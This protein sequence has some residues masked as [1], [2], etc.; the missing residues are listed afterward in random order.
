MLL[1]TEHQRWICPE[2]FTKHYWFF[3]FCMWFCQLIC[4]SCIN[5]PLHCVVLWN[6][7]HYHRGGDLVN[8]VFGD[9]MKHW[10]CKSFWNLLEAI[11]NSWK[12]VRPLGTKFTKWLM[13]KWGLE[14]LKSCEGKGTS[15]V[16]MRL[17]RNEENR[18][19]HF[20]WSEN[21]ANCHL[22]LFLS[23]QGT[24]ESSWEPVLWARYPAIYPCRNW[25]L[26]ET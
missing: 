13:N 9:L 18:Y 8:F 22:C 17:V 12:F 24:T 11:V 15:S 10:H 16:R 14:A 5:R 6:H 4:V 26:V 7:N 2:K 25:K 1:L 19:C 3:Y 23:L 21:A 20:N